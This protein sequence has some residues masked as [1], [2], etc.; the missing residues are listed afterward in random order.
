MSNNKDLLTYL[1]TYLVLSALS[2]S[3]DEPAGPTGSIKQ[4]NQPFR[5]VSWVKQQLT[6]S[7]PSPED[8][9]GTIGTVASIGLTISS[10]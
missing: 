10:R 6:R 2:V 1:L 8:I 7:N 9:A 4:L 5:M 3:P